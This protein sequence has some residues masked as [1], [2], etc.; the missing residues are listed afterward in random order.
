MKTFFLVLVVSF[1]LT[2]C[3]TSVVQPSPASQAAG[4][5]SPLQV[6]VASVESQKLDTTLALP[7]QVMLTR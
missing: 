7:A 2:G 6:A 1:I 4:A 5:G 3:S